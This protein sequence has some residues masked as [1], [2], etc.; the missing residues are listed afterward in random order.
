MSPP[1]PWVAAPVLIVIDPLEPLLAVPVMK[2]IDPLT[3]DTPALAVRRTIPPLDVAVPS[4][5]AT[6]MAPPVNG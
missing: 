5:V 1:L 6:E 4:P 2:E 3:P